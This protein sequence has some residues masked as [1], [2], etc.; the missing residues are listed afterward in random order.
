A[1]ILTGKH[2]HINGLIDNRV[3]FDGSQQTFPK[4]FHF[5]NDIDKWEPYDLQSDPDELKNL[6]PDAQYADVVQELMAELKRLRAHYKDTT[7]AAV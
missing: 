6:Y 5:Y 2:S 7:G 4:L 3:T 1:V